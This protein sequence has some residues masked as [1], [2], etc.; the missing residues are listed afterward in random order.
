[1]MKQFIFGKF[2]RSIEITPELVYKGIFPHDF[3]IAYVSQDCGFQFTIA[4]QKVESGIE[5]RTRQTIGKESHMKLI[6]L[7]TRK[8]LKA[9]N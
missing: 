1:M 4:K 8:F 5:N 2:E 7:H 3:K 6:F 9:I